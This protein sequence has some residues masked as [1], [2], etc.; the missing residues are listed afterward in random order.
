MSM[1]QKIVKT[2]TESPD[3]VTGLEFPI[4]ECLNRLREVADVVVTEDEREE[5]ILRAIPVATILMTTYGDVT[6]RVIEAGAPTLKAI[7]ELGTGID[8]LDTD[9]AR[10]LGVRVVNCPR[11]ARNAVAECAFLLLINCLK[12]FAPIHRA[13]G[14]HG[15]VAALETLKGWDLEGK[16]VGMVGLG[17]INSKLTRMCQGFDM[18]VQAY[19]PY[20]QNAEMQRLGVTRARDLDQLMAS[21]DVVSICLPLNDETKGLVSAQ[22]LQKMKKTAILIN[23]GRGAC[24]DENALVE[25]L[26]RGAI[27][28][29][30]LDV[31]AEEPL[32]KQGHPLST[33]IDLDAVVITPHLAAW[34]H[35][36]WQR[37][38]DEV[39][40][41][42]MDILDGRDSIVHSTDPRLQGQPGCV[43]PVER[44]DV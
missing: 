22:R 16:L 19:D 9:A 31:F 1:R 18:N 43:Y 14:E 8:S 20:L 25:L 36:T 21:S 44:T 15:W 38:Q 37:L 40:A 41:H 7:V 29:C 33:L 11:Y 13:V 12:K 23:V 26:Q 10:E 42:V 5:T 4:P 32:R 35:E 39:V 3:P 28:G 34:T 30:G 24:V 6:R 17:H 2:G 27:A